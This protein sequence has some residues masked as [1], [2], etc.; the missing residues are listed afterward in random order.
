MP[1]KGKPGDADYRR[2]GPGYWWQNTRLPYLSMCTSGD[3]EMMEP[4]FRMYIDEVLPLCVYRTRRYLDHGGAYYPECIYFWGDMFS[5]TYGWQPFEE[6][7]D[8]L[9][10]SGWHKW[11][12]VCGPELVHMMLDYY[13]H[14]LDEEFLAKRVLPG[15]REVM[16]FF[17]EHYPTGDDG[18]LVM[19][20]SMACETWWKCTNPM[21]ELAGL[22]ANVARLLA[23]SS[24]LTTDAQR[25]W[26]REFQAKLP[27]LPTREVAEGRALAPAA[28]FENKRNSENPELYA[29]FPF[30]LVSFE[31][32]NAELGRLALKHRWDRGARGW[33]QDDLFMAYLGL[34]ADARKNVVARARAKHSGS[35]FPAFWGP[36]YDWIPD[37]DHGGVL[38]KAVQ[39]MLLQTEGKKIFLLPAWP[40][41]WDV[42]FRLHAPHRTIVEGTVKSGRVTELRVTPTSRRKDVEIVGASRR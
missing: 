4:L 34:A 23:L 10:A 39:A 16:R 36:N 29:V 18:R 30:R 7:A 28:K 3:F 24:H 8:K 40:A 25:R 17:D 37:Q 21:P 27:E 32:P 2:W 20:P 26:W 15:A 13:D 33:R 22:R 31:K 1:Y 11:E 35:R 42:E 14:T 5:E 9:Q 12:W 38:M 41:D 19:H 6:R